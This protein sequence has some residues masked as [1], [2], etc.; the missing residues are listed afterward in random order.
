MNQ[1]KIFSFFA[2]VLIVLVGIGV[3][4]AAEDVSVSGDSLDDSTATDKINGFVKDFAEKRGVNESEINNIT[5][6]DFDALPK[7]VEIEN[8]NDNNLAIYQVNYNE[9]ETEQKNLYV[10][11][12][13]TEKLE[14]QGD[15]IVA[16]DKRMFLN[17]GSE[18]EM[19][20]GFLKTASGV[21]GSLES[22]YVMMRSGSI[23]G[24][25][26]SL[27]VTENSEAEIQIIVYKNGEQINF[28]NEISAS[29]SGVQK[30]YDI[31]SKGIVEF[32]AGDVISAYTKVV[33]GEAE[34]KSVITMVE[35]TTTN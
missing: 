17:F 14:G 25:S 33:D 23:T 9:T 21:E 18:G 29:E 12:Y 4:A 32:E 16:Q 3:F 24:V 6:V 1:K 7:E 22:G 15:I 5:E 2:V 26:T 20:K 10:I 19:T 30:D 31:Q 34:Y 8:V 35:I 27:D 28:G 13:S 11:T